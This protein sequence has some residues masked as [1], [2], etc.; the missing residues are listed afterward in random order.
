M[1][2]PIARASELT[3]AD[4]TKR[5]V[6]MVT[7]ASSGIGLAIAQQL[8]T[9]GYNLAIC[10]RRENRLAEVANTLRRQNIDVLSQ[11]VDLRDESQILS[12]FTAV[13]RQWNQLDV[14]INNAG[15]GHKESL[16][17]GETEAWREMLE[18]NVLALCICTREAISLM[19]PVNKGHI[20][21]VSSMS[22]HRVPAITGVYSATKFAVRSLTE[23]LRRE[24]RASNS[25]IRIT[26]VSPGIVETEFAQKYHQS[27]DQAA[28]T[29][30]QFPVLQAVDIA[31]AVSYALSQP[32]HVEVNDILVRPT[33]QES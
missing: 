19:Q 25:A 8:A 4:P 17:S 7:G 5:P 15:L 18:V 14:L 21:H 16:M 1:A 32:A 12:F 30:S 2:S 10:A 24:L 13:K 22:G 3:P 33:H 23:T 29:Y 9:S 31:N 6:A 11:V 20:V 28:Q 27:A 26:S